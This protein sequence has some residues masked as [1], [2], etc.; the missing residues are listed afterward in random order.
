LRTARIRQVYPA[1]D[2]GLVTADLD[3][4][5]FDGAFIGAR[6][7]VLAPAGTRRA[8]V[9]PAKYLLTRYGVDYVRL[10]R[11]G[12]LIEAPVQRGAP[13][14]L[15]NM[16]DGVEVL[17]GLRPGDQIAPAQTDA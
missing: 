6:V 7:R 15:E 5:S 10:W 13:T 1:I 9:V 3:A 11:G 4:A 16:E 17:S 14:P 12:A 2:N 8:F